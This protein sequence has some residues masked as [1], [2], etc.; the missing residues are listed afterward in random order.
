[1]SSKIIVLW[2]PLLNSRNVSRWRT[3]SAGLMD[4]VSANVVFPTPDRPF[5]QSD[6]ISVGNCMV[7]SG[8]EVIVPSI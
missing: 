6:V 3:N 5:T 7:I 4:I 1:M 8:S 2:Y